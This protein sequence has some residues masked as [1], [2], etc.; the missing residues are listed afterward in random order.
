MASYKVVGLLSGGKDSCYNL[1]ECA[2]RGHEIVALANLEPYPS[3]DNQEELDSQCF[4]TVGAGLVPAIAE[5][6]GL[7]LVRR[8]TRGEAIKTSV[9]YMHDRV[10]QEEPPDETTQR[11]EVEDLYW[12]LRDV[13]RAYPEVSAVS[14]GAILSNYQRCRV[15][16]V[17][18]RL[19]LI[20]LAFLWQREQQSLLNDMVQDGMQSI[21][22]KVASMGLRVS[23]LG[24]T[25]GELQSQFLELVCG[26]IWV[27]C[28]F[29]DSGSRA[30]IDA[31]RSI[32]TE[33]LWRRRGI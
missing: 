1:V 31:A 12:L 6:L 33:R 15:E 22:V 21:L 23:F 18:E 25:L 8:R 29:E 24:K 4:Q 20:S 7:P 13:L 16:N 27:R 26:L 11:D 14:C 9:E 17:C 3:D 10:P 19:G 30:V 5:C 28:Y 2:R 32:R